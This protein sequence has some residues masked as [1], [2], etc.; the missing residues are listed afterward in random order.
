M[1]ARYVYVE[2]VWRHTLSNILSHLMYRSFCA[3]LYYLPHHP[4]P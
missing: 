1:Y 3:L 4:L 2:R